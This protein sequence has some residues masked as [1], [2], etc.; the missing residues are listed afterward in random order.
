MSTERISLLDLVFVSFHGKV[1]A[2]SRH[3]GEEIWKW[4]ASK[5]DGTVTMLPDGD[6]LFVSCQGYTWAL[7][8][9]SGRELWY[10]PFTGEGVGIP[11]IASMRHAASAAPGIAA[12]VAAQHA[13]T[14]AAAA[15]ATV[16]ATTAAASS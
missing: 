14:T 15:A 9:A 16:A 7:D 11:M 4:K 13:A 6:R 8:A 2:I 1:F 3:T 5:G 12:A 10:Q